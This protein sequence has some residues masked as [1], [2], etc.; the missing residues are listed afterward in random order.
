MRCARKPCIWAISVA[1]LFCFLLS[2]RDNRNRGQVNYLRLG[3]K[4]IDRKLLNSFLPEDEVVYTIVHELAHNFHEPHDDQ[5]FHILKGLEEEWY[6]LCR[7]GEK[8]LGEGFSTLRISLGSPQAMGI[9]LR[10]ARQ[11]TAQKAE[12]RRRI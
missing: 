10:T 4:A 6:E 8:T 11:Q 1:H 12:G 2:S 3:E 7:T 5:F 9:S